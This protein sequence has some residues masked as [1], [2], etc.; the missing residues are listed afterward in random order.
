MVKEQRRVTM[1]PLDRGRRGVSA[2]VGVTG[3]GAGVVAV[4]ESTNQAGTVALLTIGALASVFALLGKIPLRW[5][6][7]GAELDMTYEESQQTADALTEFM[8]ADQLRLLTQR[9]LEAAPQQGASVNSLHLAATLSRASTVESEGHSRMKRF[10]TLTPGYS[11][12]PATVELGADGVMTA[13]D[14]TRIAVDFKAWG[15]G[16]TRE[17]RHQRVQLLNN[18]L[19]DTLRRTHCDALMVLTDAIEPTHD[20]G[21]FPSVLRRPMRI[22]TFGDGYEFLLTKFKELQQAAKSNV[23]PEPD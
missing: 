10:A 16:V 4:F 23:A 2:F 7:A 18:R 13:P 12:E 20:L 14:G 3:L 1:E 19:P 11:Y 6:V 21:E 9:L 8:N 15:D 5:V 17:R 22:A